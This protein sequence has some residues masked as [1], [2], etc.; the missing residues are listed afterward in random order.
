MYNPLLDCFIYVAE[1]GTF[2]KAGEIVL[3][4]PTAVMKQINALEWVFSLLPTD[5]SWI[6]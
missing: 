5:L 1:H 3:I 2:T 6:R 4:S